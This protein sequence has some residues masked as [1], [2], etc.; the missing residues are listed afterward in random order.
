MTLATVHS[1]I[2]TAIGRGA[3]Y[4]AS[5]P[6]WAAEAVRN[7]EQN[8]TFNYMFQSVDV[9]LADGD[10]TVLLQS[11]RRDETMRRYSS[12]GSWTKV[13]KREP[14]DLIDLSESTDQPPGYYFLSATA[15]PD[16]YQVNFD[17]PAGED[18]TIRTFGWFYTTYP[19]VYTGNIWLSSIAPTLIVAQVM[20]N[21]AGILRDDS[22]IGLWQPIYDRML[23][24]VLLADDDLKQ[25]NQNNVMNYGRTQ[26]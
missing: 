26:L 7:L 9:A 1:D 5:I 14:A 15:N 12:D 18:Y 22:L 24:Q 8:Y 6:L 23:R 10:D 4:D 21:K 2:S 25:S 20:L 11:L 17:V 16:E 3:T 13:H 19:G